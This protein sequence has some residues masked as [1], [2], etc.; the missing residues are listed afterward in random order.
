[1]GIIIQHVFFLSLFVGNG[2][3]SVRLANVKVDSAAGAKRGCCLVSVMCL[4]NML[5]GCSAT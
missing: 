1:M 2:K 4:A 3:I 5:G